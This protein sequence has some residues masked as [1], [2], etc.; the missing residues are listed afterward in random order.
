MKPVF[1]VQG[2]VVNEPDST[3]DAIVVGA[4]LA[5]LK[6]ALELKAAGC[7]VLVL[8]ARDRV[9]GRSKPGE[10]CGQV[11][12]LG[13]Q[14]VGPGQKLLL[15][16]AEELGVKTYPQYTQGKSLIRLDG[17]LAAS[18]ST[19]PRLPW[20]S[21]LELGLLEQG[22]K[23]ASRSLP[24]GAPWSAPRAQEW[25]AQSV[26]GWIAGN[27]RTHAAREM[28]RTV[29]RSLFCAEPSQVS[30]LCLLEFMRQAHGLQVATGV[31]GGA[32]Q[33]KFLGG[34]WQ[35]PQRM[36]ERL[37]GSIVFN[38]PV[39]AVEQQDD[40]VC[41][42]TPGGRYLARRLVMAI[43]P[44]LAAQVHY[45][46]PLP[47]KRLG[48]LQR[49]PM[50]AVI[51]IHVAYESPFWRRRGFSGMAFS[52]DLHFSA[53]FDQSPPDESLG[54]LVGFMDAAHAVEMSAR[55]EDARRRQA[56]ADLVEYFGPEAG[57]PL[58]YVD[59]DWTQE[60]W[61][62]GGY[63]AH[64]PPGVITSYGSTLR[65]PCG[66]IHWAGAETATEWAGYLDGALQSGIRASREVLMAQ[67]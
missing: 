20:W 24:A 26:E 23:R 12:D 67:G 51:K 63:V 22:W 39:Q 44:M 5:G 62:L 18:A 58:A 64:T 37:A 38:A 49:M 40:R 19:I 3:W 29:T 34:A 41:V 59:Q 65:E 17:R 32:Q 61:S 60:R 35:I 9:G 31:E 28:L 27:V 36:S 10:I 42:T 2:N 6:A 14:W 57:R 52:N 46:T 33:D 47:A 11:I 45:A 4:G 25:D 16:Q 55:G 53:V 48:L 30:Y 13:G 50:G 43:P 15:K 54:L 8:E 1:T 66:R 21:L 7:S 56:V